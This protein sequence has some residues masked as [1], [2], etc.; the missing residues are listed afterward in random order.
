MG[1]VGKGIFLNR[2]RYLLLALAGATL[3]CLGPALL[4]AYWLK[5]VSFLIISLIIACSWNLIGGY[6][7]YFSFGH[8]LF[9]GVGSYT[10]AIAVLRFGVHPYLGMFLGGVVSAAVALAIAPMLRL[11][12]FNFAL[13][14]L[15]LLEAAQ[16]IFRKWEFTRGLKGWDLGW[17]FPPLMSDARYYYLLVLVFFLTMA[18]HIVF[19]S[20][21]I[22][23][24][25][26]ALKEDD[27]MAR[28][29]GINS[30][31]TRV[32]AFVLSAFWVGVTGAIYAPMITYISSQAIF[33]LSWSVKPIIVSIFGGIGTLAGPIVGGAILIFV[34]QML[35]ERF[36]EY[37]TLIYGVLLV[38]IVTFLPGG[39]L[40]YTGRVTAWFRPSPVL[41]E[42]ETHAPSR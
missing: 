25:T 29:I 28:G 11:K 31:L 9:F 24:G 20:S 37:H 34:D 30:T 1:T 10:I 23:F 7:G 8:G 17:S 36:L 3:L 38:A 16:V 27:L 22:G 18:S 4:D 26:A 6:C 41:P 21:R 39:L 14:T 5:F 40:S 13:T 35:W 33:A 12:G 19:L 15:A 2:D 32:C 42:A